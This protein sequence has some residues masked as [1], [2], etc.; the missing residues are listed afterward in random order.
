[1]KRTIIK[2]FRVFREYE[3]FTNKHLDKYKEDMNKQI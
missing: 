1:M 2:I 3:E